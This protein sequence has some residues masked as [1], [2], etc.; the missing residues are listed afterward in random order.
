MATMQLPAMGYGLRYEYG[1]FRQAIRDG[2]QQEQPDDWL[3][4][5]D[6]CE[7]A[8][9]EEKVAVKLGCSFQM[10]GGTLHAILGKASSLIGIPFDRPVVG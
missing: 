3:R 4:R 2:W 10:R 9:P 6:P 8:R 7:V 1:M 5:P